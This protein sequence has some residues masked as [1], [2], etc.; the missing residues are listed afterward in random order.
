MNNFKIESNLSLPPRKGRMVSSQ[1]PISK[2]KVGDAF[3]IPGKTSKEV[4]A[5]Y[6]EAAKHGVKVTLRTVEEG[7]YVFRVR[8]PK[9][10]RNEPETVA[11]ETTKH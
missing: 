6:V 5:V 7:T 9:T 11:D 8:A 10:R 4:N 1:Y 3:L 2:L